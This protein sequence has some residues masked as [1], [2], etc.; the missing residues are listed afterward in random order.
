MGKEVAIRQQGGYLANNDDYY[1]SLAAE[2]A[3]LKGGGGG[4]AFMKFD[5]NDGSFSYGAEDEPLELG[6]RLI[7]NPASYMR[8]FVIWVDGTV[9]FEDMKPLGQAAIMKHELPDLGPYGEDDGPVEQQTIDFKLMDEPFTEMVFQANNVSKR[10]ALAALLKSF[11]DRYKANPGKVPVVELDESE[12]EVKKGKDGEAKKGRKIK[13]HAP[14]FKIVDWIDAEEFEASLGQG[15]E[16][17]DEGEDDAPRSSRRRERDEDDAPRSSRRTARDAD[18]GEDEPRRSRRPR[19]EDE[20]DAPRSR[21][22]ARDEDDEREEEAPRNRRAATEED[23]DAPRS[24][25]RAEPAEEDEE[26][27]PRRSSRRAA[28][29]EDEAPPRRSR[30]DADDEGEPARPAAR[31]SRF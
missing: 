1:A 6:T 13:K 30:R 19:D 8:G 18:D 11:G 23:E 26:T 22:A 28:E 3:G 25:R 17:D 12:F 31:R 20:D 7:M 15:G 21:R 14:I 9:E 27:P 10:R 24:R 4:K 16:A 2:A 29:E 5:G